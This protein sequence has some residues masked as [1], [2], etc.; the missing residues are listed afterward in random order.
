MYASEVSRLAQVI[1]YLPVKFGWLQ[2][3]PSQ[4]STSHVS[5]WAF[6][7]ARDKLKAEQ[8][9]SFSGVKKRNENGIFNTHG[10]LK[11]RIIK[12]YI[13]TTAD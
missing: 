13:I 10:E 12:L 1:G 11:K 3:S 4:H 5:K 6:P 8:T 7:D 2:L 9:A